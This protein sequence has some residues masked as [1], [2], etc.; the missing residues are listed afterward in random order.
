M[1][2]KVLIPVILIAAIFIFSFTTVSLTKTYEENSV[3]AWWLNAS[4]NTSYEKGQFNNLQEDYEAVVKYLITTVIADNPD[5]NHICLGLN[6]YGIGDISLIIYSLDGILDDLM[7]LNIS[8][9]IAQSLTNIKMS[10]LD[11]GYQIDAIRI[12]NGIISFT[13]ID[14][15]YSLTYEI[16][17]KSDFKKIQ[18]KEPYSDSEELDG[19]WKHTIS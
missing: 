6:G 1:K 17:K 4:K 18:S 14:G 11:M 10:F 2:K 15:V 16:D 5:T 19:K 7:D 9:E 12:E 13:S 3:I 8:D